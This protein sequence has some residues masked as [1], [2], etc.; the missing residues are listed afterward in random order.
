MIQP[1]QIV[2]SKIEGNRPY[3]MGKGSLNISKGKPAPCNLVTRIVN[4]LAAIRRRL[5]KSKTAAMPI[6][7]DLEY[8]SFRDTSAVSH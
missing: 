6:L 5:R 8:P 1:W 4:C 7:T 3:F 2:Q